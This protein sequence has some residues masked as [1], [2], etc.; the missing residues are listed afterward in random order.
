[1]HK[2]LERG[3]GHLGEDLLLPALEGGGLAAAAW[4]E[5][6]GLLPFGVSLGTVVTVRRVFVWLVDQLTGFLE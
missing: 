3:H 1:M 6:R 5:P 4:F 2:F